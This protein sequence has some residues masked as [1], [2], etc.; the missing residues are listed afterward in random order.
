MPKLDQMDF[1][2]KMSQK[3]DQFIADML[4]QGEKEEDIIAALNSL[5]AD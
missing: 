3:Q 5:K 2:T 4:A 1:E